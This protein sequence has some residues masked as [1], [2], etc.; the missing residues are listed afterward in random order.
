MRLFNI[1][2]KGF[3]VLSISPIFST[4]Y[5]YLDNTLSNNIEEP[6]VFSY[7][8]GKFDES[9][10]VFNYADNLTSTKPKEATVDKAVEVVSDVISSEV[11]LIRFEC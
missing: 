1:I 3:F 9:L 5:T 4:Q 10:D 6:L 2:V 8:V 7:S 11:C